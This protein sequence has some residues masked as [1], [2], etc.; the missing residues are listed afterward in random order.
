MNR[1]AFADE[2]LRLR[3]QGLAKQASVLRRRPDRLYSRLAAGG[4][5]A[6]VSTHG[7]DS[8]VAGSTA[9]PYDGPQVNMGGA[10][11]K[12]VTGGLLAALAL[13]TLGKM[14]KKKRR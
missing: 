12:G 11:K 6:G 7:L 1:R 10:L 8:I 2:L 5:L 4:G 9:N 13:K 3:P 14:S